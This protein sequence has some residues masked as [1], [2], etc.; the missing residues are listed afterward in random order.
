MTREAVASM[1][2]YILINN[3]DW[4]RL[5]L[6]FSFQI[7]GKVCCDCDVEQKVQFRKCILKLRA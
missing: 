7:I 3:T 6:V 4:H 5:A 2:Y 1:V